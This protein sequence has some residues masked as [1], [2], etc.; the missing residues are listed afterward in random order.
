MSK[1]IK[2]EDNTYLDTSSIVHNKEKLSDKLLLPYIL[3]ENNDGS[4][5]TIT[6]NDY[7]HNYKYLDICF[8]ETWGGNEAFIQ[9]INTDKTY[10]DLFCNVSRSGLNGFM[11]IAKGY[12]LNGNQI[13]KNPY[14]TC[15]GIYYSYYQ[16]SY[17]WVSDY[18]IQ[19]LKVVG[20]K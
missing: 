6:L 11:T 5:D 9:S 14:A 2:L 7:A 17:Q 15:V 8:K 10:F 19:I 16:T 20:Y 3:Y 18:D 4:G 13:T 1:S 12:Y